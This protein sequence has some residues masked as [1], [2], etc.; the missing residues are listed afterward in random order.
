M[1]ND[2]LPFCGT[3][4]GSNLLTNAEYAADAQRTIGNQ[5]GVARSKLANKALRQASM[6]ASAFAQ[7]VADYLGQN[8]VD[9][10]NAN[11]LFLGQLNTALRP[12]APEIFST[13]A[14]G[15]GTFNT[16]Y[17]FFIT[18]GNAT[19]NAT[20]TN[21]G[22]TYTVTTTIAAGLILTASGNADP[23]TSGTLTKT[24]GTGDATLT[25]T[26][27]KKPQYLVVEVQGGGGGGGG[28]GSTSGTASTNGGTTSFGTSL[29]SVGGGN[30]GL[31]GANASGAG[32]N[33]LTLNSP[34][35]TLAQKNGQAGKS[36]LTQTATPISTGVLGGD[37]GWPGFGAG[38]FGGAPGQTGSDPSGSGGGG[39]GGAGASATASVASG[40][41]GGSGAYV[42][43]E[44]PS[45]LSTYSYSIGDS[46]TGQ[47]GGTSGQAG[48]DGA[49]GYLTVSMIY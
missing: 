18:A 48:A 46:G 42:K 25:F 36:G 49:R 35:I 9:T 45:P 30:G 41:G 15:A 10:T 11:A 27:F 39:G 1:A 24:G 6:I 37:G 32:G 2:F 31:R 40:S 4:T 13:N 29:L 21:N 7:Y 3:D 34:A 22:V 26:A 8:I 12:F 17:K 20:Y 28:S 5:P 23:L 14:A 33:V 43:A 38:G 19:L 44:I 47:T 16:R